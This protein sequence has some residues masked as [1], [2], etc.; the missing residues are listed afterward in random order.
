MPESGDRDREH[1]ER[2]KKLYSQAQAEEGTGDVSL[3]M[4]LLTVRPSLSQLIQ[5]LAVPHWFNEEVVA[6]LADGDPTAQTS[7]ILQDINRLPFVRSHPRGY[8]Y[9]DVVREA[10]RRYLAGKDQGWLR[11]L[12]YRLAEIFT[13]QGEHDG[14]EETNWERVFHTL[15]CNEAA[16]FEAFD[17]LFMEARRNRR[18]TVCDTLAHMAGEQR[19]LLSP[20]GRA[21]IEYYR[22]LLA[23]SLRRWE[24]A[25]ATFQG[26]PTTELPFPL[27]GRVQLYRGL[28]L[29]AK[30]MWKQAEQV[31][32]AYLKETN[33]L[34]ENPELSARFHQ[35]L[36]ETYLSQGNLKKAEVHARRSLAINQGSRDSFGEALNFETLGRIYEKLR[37]L[38]RSQEAF[39]KS[40]AILDE[41][42]RKFDKAKIYSDLADLCLSFGKWEEVERY[43]QQAQQVKVD[44]G[45]NYGLASI[46]ANFGK[47]YLKRSDTEAS[48]RY[49]RTSL[50]LFQQ[51]SD[52]LNSA[53]IL[54]N[55]A[56]THEHLSD[57]ASALD[58][59][60]KAVQ[61]L[62]GESA[63][64]PAYH[65]EIRRLERASLKPPTPRLVDK[66][67]SNTL[68]HSG[69]GI[70]SFVTSIAIGVS[71]LTLVAIAGVLEAT[72]P[73][74]ID[75]KSATLL[76]LLMIAG[77]V[78]S[79]VGVGLGIAG[80][81]Q[82]NRKKLPS[83]LGL[84]INGVIILGVI[85][86]MVI[87]TRMP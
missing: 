53:K 85:L 66:Q 21:R 28:T 1:F 84:V 78:G 62:P 58:Y 19:V 79:V 46:Y 48:L 54:R 75:E 86:L 9:H 8:A 31:Y 3:D 24:E 57:F 81:L 36:A 39:E 49:F 20:Q 7:E 60:R 16:G 47:L 50:S 29:E 41:A 30:E 65:K 12:S 38:P 77:L 55:I 15:A 67:V 22:G 18:F 4:L 72:T 40:L 5:K 13:R 80:V 11:Q 69:L 64:L 26:L 2:F 33:D 44:A 76:G 87:G 71:E 23:F 56:L 34:D 35:R 42:G 70:A 83:I 51:F 25:E 73:G 10:L 37:D 45:D 17:G 61:E 6:A 68:K 43:Y 14:A 32:W 82:K 63:S 59:M 27:A 74:G 52:R